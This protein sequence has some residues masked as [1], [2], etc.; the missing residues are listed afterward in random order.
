MEE[1]LLSGVCFVGGRFHFLPS[2]RCLWFLSCNIQNF[3]CLLLRQEAYSHY[4]II[5]IK[6]SS[7]HKSKWLNVVIWRN[8]QIFLKKSALSQHQQQKTGNWENR[9]F[10][11]KWSGLFLFDRLGGKFKFFWKKRALSRH[12]QQQTGNGGNQDFPWKRNGLFVSK[13][14][15]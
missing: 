12:Q 7:S 6:K 14:L 4:T 9:D 8:I 15:T 5:E 3:I 2:K 10:P 11:W 13:K 1:E